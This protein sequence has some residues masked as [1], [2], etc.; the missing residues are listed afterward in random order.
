MYFYR[1]AAN[2]VAQH[3]SSDAEPR[4]SLIGVI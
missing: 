1:F 2:K 3:S 4:N